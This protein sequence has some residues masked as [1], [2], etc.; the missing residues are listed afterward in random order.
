MCKSA[1]QSA[2]VKKG[3]KVE[4]IFRRLKDRQKKDDSLVVESLVH[5]YL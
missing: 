1:K 5:G 3:E 4:K 2:V